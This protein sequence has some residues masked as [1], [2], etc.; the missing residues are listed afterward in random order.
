MPCGPVLSSAIGL[1]ERDASTSSEHVGSPDE[2][3]VVIV[4]TS[5]H[6]A[7][8]GRVEA[9]PQRI[10]LRAGPVTAVLEGGD[11]RSV[12]LGDA[13]LAR[14][15]YVAVRDVNWATIPGVINDLV[16]RRGDNSFE[17]AYRCS[18]RRGPIGFDWTARF[19]GAADGTIECFMNGVARNA[20]PYGRIGFCVLHS[21][22]SCAGASYHASG[23][24]APR[25]G[26]LPRLI[27]PPRIVDGAYQPLVASFSELEIAQADGIHVRFR[28]EGDLFEMEDERSWTD[29]SFKTFC[30][31]YAMGSRMAVSGDVLRQ[32]VRISALTSG[33]A[34]AGHHTG[35]ATA[36]PSDPDAPLA[37]TLGDAL[38]LRPPPLGL[39]SASDG[40][41][42]SASEMAALRLL[43]LA[44]LRVELRLSDPSFTATLAQAVREAE[45]L[46]CG[47]ELALFVS[48]AAEHELDGLATMLAA[49][50]VARV[51]VFHEPD[52]HLV[53][54]DARWVRLARRCLGAAIAGSPVGGG[55]NG[56]FAELAGTLR[57]T[58]AMDFVSYTANP[59]VHASDDTSI[60]ENIGTLAATV[61]S[62][63]SRAGGGPVV[64]SRLTL[65]PPF[66]TYDI[67]PPPPPGP[68]ELPAYADARQTSLFG[69]GWALGSI[70]SLAEASVQSLT[71][72]E[73][74]GPAGLLERPLN[75][76]LAARRPAPGSAFPMYHVLADLAEWRD[77]ELLTATANDPLAVAAVAAR[78]GRDIGIIVANL[79]PQARRVTLSPLPEGRALARVLDASTVPIASARPEEFRETWAPVETTGGTVSLYLAPYALTTLRFEAD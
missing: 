30:T 37:V 28:F 31:P 32:G 62:A 15:I 73:T 39:G 61:L 16:V 52:A 10:R 74:V 67:T 69:A 21:P 68:D 58:D 48:D 27:E 36:P 29:A 1:F 26:T 77:C 66:G 12:R 65:R 2:G 49:V 75:P 6:L 51:L 19:L 5:D 4:R 38:G 47:L 57:D 53:A 35:D 40:I 14:R 60:V 45:G 3:K 55:T 23:G 17:V 56:N 78:V 59:Q 34:L 43:R 7:W 71:M 44:H 54:T 70:R 46:G 20:F 64:V 72:C 42:L 24:P 50:P 76:T 13:T 18:H 79:C 25:S 22:E 33:R 9:P 8:Y 41:E 63:R 11:L